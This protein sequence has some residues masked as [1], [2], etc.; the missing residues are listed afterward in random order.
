MSSETRTELLAELA[1]YVSASMVAQFARLCSDTQIREFIVDAKEQ[2]AA[3]AAVEEA[4][5]ARS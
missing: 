1:E 3:H 4:R 2:R 5:K